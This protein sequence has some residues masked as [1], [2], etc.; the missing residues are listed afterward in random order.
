[1]EHAGRKCAETGAAVLVVRA[2]LLLAIVA[3][4]VC[5]GNPC[6]Q[7]DPI[8]IVVLPYYVEDGYDAKALP[9]FSKHYRRLIGFIQNQLVRHNYEVIDPFA[10]D[11]KEMEYNNL[12]ER[13]RSDSALACRE[14][15]KRY[16]TDAAYVVWMELL[17]KRTGDGMCKVR[18]RLD[19]QGYDS[20]SRSLG[21]ALSKT[22]DVTREDCSDAM[23][24]AE[25]EVGDVVGRTLT[26]STIRL[27]PA[28]PPAPPVAAG[29]ETTKGKLS[30]E[31]NRFPEYIEVRLDGAIA[32][33]EV[34]VFGKVVNTVRGVE[35][36]KLFRSKIKS[37]SPQ[38][39]VVI[40]RVKIQDT[41][42]FRLQTNIIK[43]IDDV[44]A[45]GGSTTIKGV[46]YRY[47]PDELVMLKGIRTGDTSTRSVHFVI[48]RDRARTKEFTEQ[49][50]RDGFE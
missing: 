46:P 5:V 20:A 7:A 44:L 47:T 17:R 13:S 33:E 32:Q 3:G 41:E 34:E 48:D 35:E 22:F 49:S 15:C 42:P 12:M 2:V 27:Q 23:A 45:A 31:I 43:M 11:M 19:G 40:W 10:A 29:S 28:L 18:I 21:V 14:M 24:E 36:A 1:M 8:R 30:E 26:V 39:S 6:A 25:K 38:E 37:T 4:S 16:A 9:E 50:S